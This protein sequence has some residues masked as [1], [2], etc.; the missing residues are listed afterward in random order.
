MSEGDSETSIAPG[1]LD[2]YRIVDCSAMISGPLA[3]MMLGDQGADVIK[4]EPPGTGDGVRGFG[5]RRP[6]F[7]ALFVTTNRSKRSIA[8]DLK[9]KRGREVLLKL[10]AGADVFV[11][12]FRPGVVERMGIGYDDIR[13]V[14]PD[15]VYVSISGFGESGPY[16]NA[17]VYDPVIQALSGLAAIQS[18]ENGRPRMVRTVVP[19]KLTAVTAAQAITAALLTRTRSGEGQ[20]LRLAMLDIMVAFLWPEGMARHT[21]VGDNEGSGRPL[22][23]RDLIFETQDGYITVGAI[24]NREWEGLCRVLERLDWLEDPRFANA[25]TRVKHIDERLELTANEIVK[26][27]TQDWLE[28][29]RAEQVPC[30]PV[31]QREDLFNDPQILANKLL[32]ESV[33]PLAGR[34]IQPRP[35]ARF[36]KTPAAIRRPAP[37][38]GQHTD[39]ILQQLG[40]S[41]TEVAS[42]RDDGVVSG[43]LVAIATESTGPARPAGSKS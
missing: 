13:A 10:A 41:D 18:D 28:R 30:A 40:L 1:P 37:A 24:S 36:E 38:L 20:H 27:T 7:P 32:V 6:G 25:S 43:E 4:V 8:L 42:L 17:R 12:N 9:Q 35:A 21:Y 5:S 15:I 16:R 22:S 11:Q 29:L 2:G 19:D 34:M 23:K 33:H 26:R 14:R 39:E 3:T 31:L